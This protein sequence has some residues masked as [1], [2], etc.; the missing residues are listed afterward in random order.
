MP[1]KFETFVLE[2]LSQLRATM[3]PQFEHALQMN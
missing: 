1:Q 2:N 3:G